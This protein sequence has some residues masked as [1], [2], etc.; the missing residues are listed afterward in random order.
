M[1]V[2]S[3]QVI[4]VLALLITFSFGVVS[5]N[6]INEMI[7]VVLN[8]VTVEINGVKMAS[9]NI[10]YN[11]RTYVQLNE[12]CTKLNKELIWNGDTFT[13]GIIDGAGNQDVT[14]PS[15]YTVIP[16][17]IASF[18][19]ETPDKSGTKWYKAES[20]YTEVY[21]FNDAVDMEWIMEDIDNQ[22]EYLLEFRDLKWDGYK[23]PIYFYGEDDK[24][25]S[26]SGYYGSGYIIDKQVISMSADISYTTIEF[27]TDDGVVRFKED[28]RHTLVHEMSHHVNHPDKMSTTDKWIEEGLAYYLAYNYEYVE[29]DTSKYPEFKQRQFLDLVF[30]D[31]EAY[32]VEGWLDYLIND[33][34]RYYTEEGIHTILTFNGIARAH[35]G[36][37]EEDT[38]S[39]RYIEPIVIEFLI[40]TYGQDKLVELYK[41]LNNYSGSFDL[42][43]EIKTVYN[44]SVETLEAEFRTYANLTAYYI[45]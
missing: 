2:K 35:Y 33:E 24:L 31:L 28:P 11:G 19:G 12:I 39:T 30:T 41:N 4:V 37:T 45:D 27:N 32:S 6:G 15:D 34:F 20:T 43:A 18:V 9:D 38:P 36:M 21:F 29:V 26:D 8:K 5:A 25:S 22:F 23:L 7:D 10:L 40:E 3:K 17:Q 42:D 44:K 13:A 14:V 1:K 16:T